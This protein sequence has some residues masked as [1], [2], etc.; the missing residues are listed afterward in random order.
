[1]KG[2]YFKFSGAVCSRENALVT[3]YTHNEKKPTEMSL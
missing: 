3:F 2:L 1:M